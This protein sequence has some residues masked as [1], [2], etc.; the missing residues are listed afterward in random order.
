MAFVTIALC[1]LLWLVVDLESE[2]VMHEMLSYSGTREDAFRLVMRE[3]IFGWIAF[4]LIWLLLM[5]FVLRN[6]SV[7][8][9]R[10]ISKRGIK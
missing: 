5:A 2:G 9:R 8:R 6:I 3:R 1:L 7:L 10:T 4:G